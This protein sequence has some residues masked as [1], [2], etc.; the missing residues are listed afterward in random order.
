MYKARAMIHHTLNSELEQSMIEE[1]ELLVL[2]AENMAL[3]AIHGK[4]K[5]KNGKLVYIYLIG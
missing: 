5:E 3:V 1:A 2:D 4:A